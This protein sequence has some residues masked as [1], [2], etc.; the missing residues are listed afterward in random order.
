MKKFTKKTLSLLLV[1]TLAVTSF[2]GC[3]SNKKSTDK[4]SSETKT[5][6]A[7]GQL[8]IGDITDLTGDFMSGWTSGASDMRV[9]ELI[10]TYG[11]NGYSTIA[12]AK[13]GTFV[14]NK[15]VLKDF[16]SEDN[17]DGT[18][19]FTMTINDGLTWN[20]GTAITAKDYVFSILLTSS[21]QW[22]ELEADTTS[23]NYIAGYDDF[24]KGTTKEFTGVHL[25]SDN[26][27]SITVK[28]EKLPFFYELTYAAATPSPMAVYAPGVTLKDDGNGAYL[29]KEFTTALI[30]DPINKERYN[31]TVTCG[32]YKVE[33]FDKGGL[34]AT[35]VVNDK[36]AGDYTGQ[37]PQIEKIIIKKV[38]SATAADELKTGNV[39]MLNQMGGA[40]SI[41]AGLDL[42]DQGI[43]KDNSYLRN[44]YGMI[45]FTCDIGPTQFVKVRQ[46]IAHLLDRNEFANQYS[47]GY[48]SVV[49]GAYGLAQWMY[50]E[51]KDDINSKL[52]SYAYDIDAAK[53]LLVEDGWT[54]NKD[55]KNFV[56][57]TDKLRYKKVD[58]KLMPLTIQ[59]ANT[60]NNP[61]SDLLSTMLPSSMEKVG[62]KLEATTL[63]W[64]VL[65]N[66]IYRQGID[67]PKYNMFNMGNSFA[68]VY[69]PS[70]EY[71]TDDSY[72]GMYNQNYIR[73]Q[74]LYDL[75]LAMKQT[76]SKDKE[77]YASK[78]VEFEKQWNYDLP[79]LPLYSDE[80]H[81]FYNPKLV[82]YEGN[83][84]WTPS[85]ALLYAHVK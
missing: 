40:D 77:G 60:A 16:K 73:D 9:R 56:E 45:V 10:G 62:M 76:D 54:L 74:K 36:Y 63:D 37:K 64:G 26:Q 75:A 35:L 53:K 8:I 33:S 59:W 13:D 7:S 67:K 78:W 72:M 81:D 27:F 51:K 68:S 21:K 82:G 38:T 80:Y 41:N 47:G 24:N 52:D 55:G 25:L 1:L 83:S 69:D 30:K 65:I 15:T 43:A 3:S 5:A 57:G 11:Y 23:G 66:N 14:Q 34:T 29:S 4:K 31:P 28:K 79:D 20:D 18:K 22:G 44:G 42:V 32:P 17:S 71:N 70:N 2:V 39:D 48:A 19:T 46:A 49:N 50:Q 85:Y 84:I 6:K 12:L 58:G 61:V